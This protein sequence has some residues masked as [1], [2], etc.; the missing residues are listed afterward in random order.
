MKL[1]HR[2]LARGG[3]LAVALLLVAQ[4]APLSNGGAARQS[5]E[6]PDVGALLSEVARNERAMLQ[7][8]L[9]YTWTAKVTTASG[10][11]AAR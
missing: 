11:G 7:R 8:R 5:A 9:E 4:A 2:I 6:G 3:R 1:K 10:T